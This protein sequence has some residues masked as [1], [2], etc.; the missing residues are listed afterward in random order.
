MEGIDDPQNLL[1]DEVCELLSV[2]LPNGQ[3]V[4]ASL[5]IAILKCM[6]LDRHDLMETLQQ[7]GVDLKRIEGYAGNFMKIFLLHRMHDYTAL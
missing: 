6:L 2:Q 4:H 7:E 1:S 3:T 5:R